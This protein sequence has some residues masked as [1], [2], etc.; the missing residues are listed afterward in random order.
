MK[1]Y[2][3]EILRLQRQAIIDMCK[4]V[5]PDSVEVSYI[6]LKTHCL[7][8]KNIVE[9]LIEEGVIKRIGSSRLQ[10]NG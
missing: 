4:D 8:N 10:F 7:V 1:D 3:K 6:G 2:V 9:E 5:Y